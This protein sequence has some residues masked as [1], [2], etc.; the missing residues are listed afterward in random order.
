MELKG[1]HIIKYTIAGKYGEIDVRVE[2]KQHD[3]MHQPRQNLWYGVAT[4]NE[5]NY[6]DP[7]LQ[8]CVNAQYMAEH[9]ADVELKK[10]RAKHGSKLRVKRK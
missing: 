6:D 9:I 1:K 4:L 3:G 8:Y 10:L 5:K 2:L 7:H